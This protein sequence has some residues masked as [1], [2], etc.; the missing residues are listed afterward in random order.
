MTREEI[1][2]TRQDRIYCL[3]ASS[4]YHSEVCE[5]C[6]FYSNCDHTAQDDMTELTITDLE[7][8]EQ[9]PTSKKDLAHNLCHSCTNVGCV[10]QFGIVRTECAFYMPPHI[11]PDN[12]GNY[13][14]Q[15]LTTKN[16]L[17]VDAVSRKRT[18]GVLD[19]IRAEIMS[20]DGLEEALE[21][22]DKYRA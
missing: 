3:K 7:A 18:G 15:D 21:I 8:L 12:C 4:D 14:V 19:K 11:E 9:E 2:V 10:F 20:K 1:E 6:K 16:D 13:V 5:E 17:G 22:I